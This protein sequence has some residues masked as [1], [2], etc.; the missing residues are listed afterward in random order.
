MGWVAMDARGA[1]VH[2]RGGTYLERDPTIANVVG[3]PT[4]LVLAVNLLDVVD[5]AHSVAQSLGVTELHRLPD[6]RQP[7]GLARVNREVEVLSLDEVKGPKVLRRGEAIFGSRDVEAADAFVAKV[8]RE[9]GDGL[10]QVGLAHGR[11]DGA[12]DDATSFVGGLF[13]AE[14]EA[15]KGGSH[16]LVQREPAIEVLFGRKANLGVDNAVSRQIDGA[17]GRNPLELFAGLHERSRVGETLQIAHEV[18]AGVHN[19]PTTELLRVERRQ[20]LIA[21]LA[22]EFN[23]RLWAQ[24]AVEVLV[25][26]DLRGSANDLSRQR[27]HRIRLAKEV[28]DD[29]VKRMEA[30]SGKNAR[31]AR[32]RT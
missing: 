26:K 16:D 6:R 17:L 32:G 20:S 3:E 15:V 11:E 13:R 9:L 12:H 7:K 27:F 25:Q 5:D 23:D 30:V 2:V 19:E 28:R 24:P 14:R 22:R 31:S 29:A 21:R 4:E 1:G 18:A 8:D 10:A